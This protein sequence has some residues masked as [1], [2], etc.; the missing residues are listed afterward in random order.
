MTKKTE[1]LNFDAK[2]DEIKNILFSNNIYKIPR[3]QRPYTWTEDHAADFWSDLVEGTSSYFIGSF[4]LNYEDYES[5]KHIEVIDGQQRLLTITIFMAVIRDMAKALNSHD[6]ARRIQSKCIADE[7]IRGIESFRIEPGEST[8]DYFQLSIQKFEND[9]NRMEPSSSE[10]KRIYKNYFY[11]K[12]KIEN[13]LEKYKDEKEKIEYLRD[14][15]ERMCKVQA[16]CIRIESEEDAY[17]IFETVNARGVDLSVADLLKNLIFKNIR[18]SGHQKDIVKDRWS[19]IEEN[20]KETNTEMSKFLRY[21]WLSKYS[22]VTEKKLFKEIKKEIVDYKA[23][24]NELHKASIWYYKLLKG[25]ID[26]W[27]EI[28]KGNVIFKKLQAMLFN[29]EKLSGQKAA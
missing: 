18:Q 1:M 20:I 22:F 15:F 3:Y 11:F 21:Y 13:E 12:G 4:V 8:R 27:A 10:Q 5:K 19:E 9:I 26:E 28:P 2:N 7:D 25:S 29:H 24:L 16:I 23:F 6:T 17:E 14:L